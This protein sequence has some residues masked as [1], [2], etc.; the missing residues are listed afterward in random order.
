MLLKDSSTNTVNALNELKKNLK[1][2][3]KE[4]AKYESEFKIKIASK[5]KQLLAINETEEQI[6][7]LKHNIKKQEAIQLKYK[8]EMA[9]PL[10][11]VDQRN[12][13][14][15]LKQ[16]KRNWVRKIEIAELEANKAKAILRRH[17]RAWDD[18]EEQ[19]AIMGGQEA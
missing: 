13:F 19:A 9:D 16:C 14:N 5:E 7:H 15:Q 8:E 2:A 12:N 11:F 17:G 6:Q 10:R 3:E 4:Q 18:E 1:D